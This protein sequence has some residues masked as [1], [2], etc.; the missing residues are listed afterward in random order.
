MK[1][2]LMYYDRYD[3]ATTSLEL[4]KINEPHYVLCHNNKE[5]FTCIGKTGTLVETNKPRGIQHNF[6][7]GLDM[8]EDG[9]WGIFLSDDYVSSKKLVGEKFIDCPM[10]HPLEELKNIIP[11]ADE[12][13]IKLIGL[14]STGNPFY[15]QKKYSKYG[16]VDGRCFAIKK[17]DFRW[18]KGIST[19]TDYYVTVYHLK[20]YG[21]NLILNHTYMDFERYKPKGLGSVEERIPDKM[22]DIELMMTL[23]PD[24]IVVKDKVNQPK[25][26]HIV[27]KR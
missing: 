5:R 14:S 26:S 8:L 7:F 12:A 3:E 10:S 17:T 24:N 20:K 22:H 9:E 1:I 11:K 21:G 15:A 4:D 19:V 25:G 18:H 16:L 27:I 6:N 23:F 2:I 13:G